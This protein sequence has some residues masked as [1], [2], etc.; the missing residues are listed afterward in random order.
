MCAALAN[1]EALPSVTRINDTLFECSEKSFK[2]DKRIN[3]WKADS[4]HYIK[5]RIASKEL[6]FQ[7][8]KWRTNILL[9]PE[10]DLWD[11]KSDDLITV[12]E[13]F[14]RLYFNLPQ[15]RSS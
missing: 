15:K 11:N 5:L 2:S 14:V 3:V 13:L 8:N 7:L 9:N 10:R 12:Y 4:S 6:A 1:R